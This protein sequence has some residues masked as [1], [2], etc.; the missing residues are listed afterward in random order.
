MSLPHAVDP[1]DRVFRV[2]SELYPWRPMVCVLGLSLESEPDRGALES[3]IASWAGE[4]RRLGW[5]L[6]DRFRWV[7][8]EP[9]P[10]GELQR[11]D[12]ALES[13]IEG[14]EPLP[15][16]VPPWRLSVVRGPDSWALRL[17]W[18]HALSDGEGMLS[19]LAPGAHRADL[20]PPLVEAGAL[21][22]LL[23]LLREVNDPPPLRLDQGSDAIALR[24]LQTDLSPGALA[25]HGGRAA[26]VAVSAHALHA[27]LD[28]PATVRI[29]SP[30]FSARVPGE[31]LQLGNHRR[32]FT[33]TALAPGTLPELLR[34]AAQQAS[35]ARITPY[36]A[37]SAV[38]HLPVGWVDRILRRAP[39]VIVNWDSAG[40]ASSIEEV[41]G[42]RVQRLVFC[43][44]LLPHQGCTFLWWAWRGRMCCSL[45][46]DR[47]LIPDVDALA[48]Q[49]EVSVH[50]LV[51]Q[52][53]LS[54]ADPG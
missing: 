15:E 36:A 2:F 39:P 40:L 41:A 8:A 4:H 44:P 1:A 13:L 48:E 46:V 27:V 10:L 14:V 32:S 35:A 37:L 23:R 5:C 18:H 9:P 12:D 28:P 49:L 50:A 54:G 45:T 52:P 25:G 47:A 42:A 16:G 51:Q 53:E 38:G 34:H 21:A 24:T 31:P 7:E 30:S 11:G 6:E 43:P 33:R 20:Q 29:L 22:W 19:L 26:L 3:M 17:V